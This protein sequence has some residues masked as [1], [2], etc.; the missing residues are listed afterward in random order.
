LEL[1]EAQAFN[2]VAVSRKCSEVPALQDAIEN[3]RINVSRAKRI[4]SVIA[5]DNAALWIEKAQKL[6]QRELEKEVAAVKPEA[7][8]R[9]MLKPTGPQ[10]ALLH[11]GI[12][13]EQEKKIYRAKEILSQKLQRPVSLEETLEAV[14]DLFLEKTDPIRKAQR[15]L[16]KKARQTVSPSTKPESPGLEGMRLRVPA[17][18]PVPQTQAKETSSAKDRASEIMT[19]IHPVSKAPAR[20]AH[21]PVPAL[22]NPRYIPAALRHQIFYRDQGRCRHKNPDGSRCESRMFLQIHHIQPLCQGGTTTLENLITVCCAHH[23]HVHGRVGSGNQH[24]AIGNSPKLRTPHPQL[25][26]P[27]R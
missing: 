27:D 22:S 19:S 14:F 7:T 21:P 5:K 10:R 2:F 23:Q 16:A 8:P 24:S 18:T 26:V 9:P 15:V 20:E 1:S 25:P 12:S 6:P 4:V 11:C 17:Q 13:Q 3:K